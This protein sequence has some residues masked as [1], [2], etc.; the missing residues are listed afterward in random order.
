MKCSK[1]SDEHYT[2][3]AKGEVVK[4]ILWLCEGCNRAFPQAKGMP[5]STKFM[6]SKLN[7]SDVKLSNLSKMV[8]DVVDRLSKVEHM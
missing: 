2:L 8:N 6:E 4:S 5:K 1:L 7:Q 3:L